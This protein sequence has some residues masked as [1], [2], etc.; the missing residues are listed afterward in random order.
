MIVLYLSRWHMPSIL[1]AD[2]YGYRWGLT[3]GPVL[4]M[5]GRGRD[6]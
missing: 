3:V 5:F 1:P 6:A 4:I 2:Y